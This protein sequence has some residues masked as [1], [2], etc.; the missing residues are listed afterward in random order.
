MGISVLPTNLVNKIA[1]GEVIERP[2]SVLKELVENSLDAGA[3]RV[4]IAVEDG[5]RKL[6]SVTDDGD[7]MGAEDVALAF[8]P[9]A[10]SKIATEDELFAISTMG[11]RGEAL[12]AVAAVSHARI[13]S[14]TRESHSGYEIT[15]SGARIGEPRPC[16]APAGTSVSVRDLF[17]NTPAR[18]KFMRSANTEFGHICDRLAHLAIPHP[19]V[20]FRVTHNGRESQ[21]L[22]AV[23]TTLK[24]IG[25]LFGEAL[26]QSLVP[27]RSRGGDVGIAGFVGRPEAAR[28]SSKWQ[29]FFLNG[30]YIRDRLLAHAV[31]EA[32]RGLIDQ[33][34]WPV[35]FVFVELGPAEVDVN[36]HPTKIEVRF[37]NSQ[38]VH[39]SLLAA[40]RETLNQAGLTPGAKLPP[41]SAPRPEGDQ[42]G[43][44]AQANQPE[45]Q[46]KASLRQA[47][48]DFFKSAPPAQPR[49]SFPEHRPSARQ[50]PAGEGDR[51]QL[52]HPKATPVLQGPAD[53]ESLLAGK[54]EPQ[55]PAAAEAIQVHNSYIVAADDEGLIIVDQH[56]LHER[57]IYN[58]LKRRLTEGP[59]T[60]QRSLVP[61]TLKV[62][63]AE[64]DALEAHEQL[65]ARL[66]IELAPFGPN[67]LAVQRFPSLLAERAVAPAAVVRALADML[68][69][70]ET[71]DSERLLEGV[72]EMMACKAAVKA[73]DALSAAEI[74]ELLARRK[75]AEKASAC[76]HGRPTTL[77]LTLKE[78][79]KQFKRT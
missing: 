75:E 67:T 5:G 2:A 72:L 11:F 68:S 39:G 8:A 24:R 36:V 25:D 62:T 26:A 42:P 74:Q 14:R 21:N 28:A 63:E 13:R 22:P 12:A 46:R 48:A 33:Q 52:H 27:M 61:E 51:P 76:P 53:A 41:P 43:E 78:L 54:I 18:R 69:E 73:G 64:A 9:H 77:K 32:H 38:S 49:F 65:L 56:A 71:A 70:G 6:I 17:F 23:D 1:A 66:G 55:M 40:L 79:E 59:L 15:A 19:K 44:A 29:Y 58:G 50:R 34:R 45:A 16:A 35:A 37:R 60:A 10:T 3:G 30:R 31:R 57:L 7:G 20:A 4:D 47:L